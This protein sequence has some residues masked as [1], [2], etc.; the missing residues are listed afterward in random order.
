VLATA[1]ASILDMPECEQRAAV[2]MGVPF[3]EANDM[4]GVPL[5]CSITL[6]HAHDVTRRIT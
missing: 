1:D 3:G 2:G 4:L 5:D 6:H